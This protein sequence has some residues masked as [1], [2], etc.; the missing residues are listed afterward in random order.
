MIRFNS[1]R[2]VLALLGV[3]AFDEV[4]EDGLEY[5]GDFSEAEPGWGI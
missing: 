5:S 2:F 1:G 3:G 4:A